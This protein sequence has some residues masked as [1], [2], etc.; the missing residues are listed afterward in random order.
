M[1]I[2]VNLND[3]ESTE[4]NTQQSNDPLLP[5]PSLKIWEHLPVAGAS[6]AIIYIL[7]EYDHDPDIFIE[8][9]CVQYSDN[10][11]I[12]YYASVAVCFVAL[13]YTILG[14]GLECGV[15]KMSG[16]G[17][18]M[19]MHVQMRIVPVCKCPL[20]PLFLVRTAGSIFGLYA[21][22]YTEGYCICVWEQFF[23]VDDDWRE[24]SF[25]P[26]ESHWFDLVKTLAFSM[27]FDVIFYLVVGC[28]ILKKRLRRWYR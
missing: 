24:T 5:M 2:D 10:Y 7:F 16:M 23:I 12:W 20:L 27:G 1:S 4:I 11:W 28:F 25:C 6:A 8:T 17:T 18:P 19:E 21:V 22:F 14:A 13:G 3:K 15:W 9:G 26:A